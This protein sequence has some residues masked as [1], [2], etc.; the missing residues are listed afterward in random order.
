MIEEVF[1]KPW[2]AIIKRL[3]NIKSL[4]ISLWHFYIGMLLIKKNK[5]LSSVPSQYSYMCPIRIFDMH[6]F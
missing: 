1:I 3:N 6:S 5:L 4:K 2:N